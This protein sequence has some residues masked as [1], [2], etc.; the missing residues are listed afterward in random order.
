MSQRAALYQQF[1]PTRPLE[2]DEEQLYVDWQK[3]LG[4]DD[5]KIRLAEGIALSG[6]LPVCRLFTGHRG[7]GKTTELKRVKRILEEG[8][9]DGKRFVCLLE[10]EQ[11]MHLE[12]VTPTDIVFHMARQIVDD[13]KQ[14]G[15]GFGVTKL[16]QFFAEIGEIL[17]QDVELKGIK[18]PTGL[19]EFSLA[20]KDNPVARGPLRKLLAGHLPNIFDLINTEILKE[21]R[22]WLRKPAHGGYED[23]LVIVDQLDR[24]LRARQIRQGE[25]AVRV[26]L[27]RADNRAGIRALRRSGLH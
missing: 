25:I 22:E 4:L 20:L 9:G 12:H 24:I 27:R 15:F 14:A 3:E 2:A 26:E 5:V 13:L 18:I 19:G 8:A 16:T 11:W 7:V 21:A 6:P 1:D 17:S 10:A 23:I